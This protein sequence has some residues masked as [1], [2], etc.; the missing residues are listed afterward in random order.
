VK[1]ATVRMVLAIVVSRDWPVQ[2]LDVKDAFLHDTLSDCFLQ[3]AYRVRESSSPRLGLLPAQ[4]LVRIKVG[5]RSIVQ[6]VRHLSALPGG[7]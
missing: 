6:S 4:V 7:C 5:A 3:S 1:P 2:Q